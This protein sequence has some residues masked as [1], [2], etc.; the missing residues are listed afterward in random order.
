MFE[1]NWRHF[2]TILHSIVVRGI[3][4]KGN[5]VERKNNLKIE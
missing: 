5:G 4:Y 3:F 2:T 1:I